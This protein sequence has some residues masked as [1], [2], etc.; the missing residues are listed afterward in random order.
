MRLCII[1]LCILINEG[2]TNFDTPGGINFNLQHARS[3]F[4]QALDSLEK[5]LEGTGSLVTIALDQI[6][7]CVRT[8]IES[9]EEK[10]EA[11]NIN[12]GG[13]RKPAATSRTLQNKNLSQNKGTTK[14]HIDAEAW[15]ELLDSIA[16]VNDNSKSTASQV[17][18]LK[19][20]PPP[21]TPVDLIKEAGYP[22]ESHYVITPPGYI[23][24]LN[25]IPH[26]KNRR[27]TKRVAYLQHGF[28]DSTYSWVHDF[29]GALAYILAD[30]GYD[31]WMGDARGNTYSRN[32]TTLDPDDDPEFWNYSWHD[33]AVED[34]PAI[35]DYIIKH[36]GTDGIYYVGHS[37]GG[38]M[39]YAMTASK[40]EMNSKIKAHVSMSPITYAGH[41]K[42][43]V[44]KLL[45]DYRGPL[46]KF[47]HRIG[48]NEFL[49]HRE[50]GEVPASICSEGVG[51]IL[52]SMLLFAIEGYGP[53]QMNVT[54][55]SEI[56]KY[57]P[58]GASIKQSLHF[59][60]NMKSGR[61]AQFDYGHFGNLKRYGSLS[62]P[63]YDLKKVTAPT[64]L[65]YTSSD[66][67]SDAM[68]NDKVYEELPNCIGRTILKDPAFNHIDLMYGKYAPDMIYRKIVEFFSRY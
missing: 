3:V 9:I 34:L 30:A 65:I 28:I 8:V 6:K 31:V 1:I 19:K 60:A 25:R 35:I 7:V 58:A 55:T 66:W 57:I 62:P 42:S 2:S 32:H 52:C 27:K 12:K 21:P 68:D 15:S 26:G 4:S 49:P 36:T 63:E 14:G 37:Q 64:Y 39:F 46:E 61:F 59:L 56:M 29:G 53:D 11:T 38:T 43:P 23:L 51:P 47:L 22:A 45:A 48:A 44:M 16:E 5:I 10:F 54:I 17:R 41:T 33:M 18:T 50:M 20:L 24:N 40:P 67:L 13:I